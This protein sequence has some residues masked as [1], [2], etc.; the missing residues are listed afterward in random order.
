MIS[1]VYKNHPYAG[2]AIDAFKKDFLSNQ[3]GRISIAGT[4]PPPQLYGMVVDSGGT[5]CTTLHMVD[6]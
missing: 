6:G 5:E 1:T 4:A 2:L 3:K